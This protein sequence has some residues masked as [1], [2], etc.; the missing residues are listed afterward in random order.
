MV[1]EEAVLDALRVV[2]D[3][4]LGRDIVSLGFIK[5]LN[6][7]K[8]EV[9]FTVELTTP[10]CPVRERFKTQ[11]EQAVGALPGVRAV[12]VKMSAREAQRPQTPQASSL[13]TVNTLIA[14]SACKGGV[15][16]ST[17]AV[18]LARALR[19]QGLAV[20][21]LDADLFGPSLPTLLNLHQ[22]DVYMQ[23]GHRADR[24]ARAGHHVVRLSYRRL[25]RGHAGTDGRRLYRTD[26]DA[27]RLGPARLP[28]LRHAARHRRRPIDDHPARKD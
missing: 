6:I 21:L 13:E 7:A 17:I 15:G 28:C 10:A 3:P 4:D 9:S 16:K 22:P 12:K 1:T 25:A 26:P 18:L 24:G 19:E 27:D 2:M 14:V 5:D 11:C 20:G 23:G 8:G